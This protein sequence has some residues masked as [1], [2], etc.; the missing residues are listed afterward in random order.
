MACAAAGLNVW[1]S[2]RAEDQLIAKMRAALGADRFD[3]AFAEGSRLSRS[4][5]VAAAQ[6]EPQ[7][8]PG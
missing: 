8:T 4:E 3:E 5:A 6:L 2:V 7:T 1:T